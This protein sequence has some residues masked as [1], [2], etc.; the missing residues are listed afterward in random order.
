MVLP[1]ARNNK[2]GAV[3][4]Q[5]MQFPRKGYGCAPK[6]AI[7]DPFIS[8]AHLS[9]PERWPLPEMSICEGVAYC[10]MSHF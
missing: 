6:A 4:V 9:K 8:L 1:L 10:A 5:A 7:H 2:P 3:S